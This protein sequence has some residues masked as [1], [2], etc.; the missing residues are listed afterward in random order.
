MELLL[1]QLHALASLPGAGSGGSAAAEVARPA[2]R[3]PAAAVQQQ[4]ASSS[5][6][7]AALQPFAVVDELSAGSPAADAGLQLWD[8]L[9]SFAGVTQQTPSTLQAVAAA[10]HAHEGQ[11]VEA[12]VLRQ[13]ALLSL[14]LTPRQWGGRGLLGCHLRPL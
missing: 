5:P 4:R 13:G 7:A 6:A 14:Q 8:Q 11:A 12:L 10:L 2:P 3:P 1:H 9:C